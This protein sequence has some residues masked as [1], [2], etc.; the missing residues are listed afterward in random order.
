MP[1]VDIAIAIG[2]VVALTK[3]RAGQGVDFLPKDGAVCPECG[4]KRLKI[5]TTRAWEN[6]CRV[7]YHRCTNTK[8][9]MLAALGFV[10]KSVQMD[11]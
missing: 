10:I 4:A 2:K 7:R 1:A 11:R 6:G 8:N 5:I 9:C 3:S